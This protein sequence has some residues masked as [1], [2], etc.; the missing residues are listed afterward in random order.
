[1]NGR[2]ATNFVIMVVALV[3]IGVGTQA[4]F[5]DMETSNGNVFTGQARHPSI[6]QE[7]LN[8]RG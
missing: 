6:T 5:S 7:T 8:R 1:M 3:S 4:Y 2:L